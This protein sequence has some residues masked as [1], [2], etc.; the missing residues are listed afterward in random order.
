[1][2][3]P[4]TNE[5]DTGFAVVFHLRLWN[6]RAH[7]LKFARHT[8]QVVH[9]VVFSLG[10]LSFFV[11]TAAAR[12]ISGLRMI[13][14]RQ[15]AITNAV[16]I[17]ILVAGKSAQPF[18]VHRG[19]HLAALNGLER[20]LKAVGHPVIHPQIKVSHDEHWSLEMFGEIKRVHGHAEALFR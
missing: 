2:R 12:E 16:A 1:M 19:Q 7:G 14:S 10:V 20:V 8:V 3:G 15:R 5:A 6:K 4:E 17:H 9:V 13:G 11:M 18:E